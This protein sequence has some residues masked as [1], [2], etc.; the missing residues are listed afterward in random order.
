MEVN[1]MKRTIL[2]FVIGAALALPAVS[3]ARTDRELT[4]RET[5]IW[6]GVIRFLRVESG[7]KIL[8]KDKDAGYVLFEY[9]EDGAA[10]TASF[11]MVRTIR[12]GRAFVRA[13]LQIAEMPRYVEAVLIDKL[14][15]RLRDEYGEPPPA[16]LIAPA[17]KPGPPPAAQDAP[18]AP[19][20][21]VEDPEEKDEADLEP[22]EER[23]EQ[24]AEGE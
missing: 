10:H 8:E 17:A 3:E 14:V 5:E 4:Y 1:V 16:E 6:Q 19:K 24:D 12:D 23:L 9:K 13:R 21:G 22:T 20:D 7:F 18:A 11:E 15:R 2:A